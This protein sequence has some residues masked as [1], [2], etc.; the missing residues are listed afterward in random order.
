MGTQGTEA[1]TPSTLERED[2]H[3]SRRALGF[4]GLG[5]Y[6]DF[7]DRARKAKTQSDP[8]G[9]P[10]IGLSV[11]PYSKAIPWLLIWGCE[12]RTE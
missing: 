11:S 4:L 3:G 9:V 5:C 10:T 7:R 6:M 2:N 1:N 8:K 12:Y